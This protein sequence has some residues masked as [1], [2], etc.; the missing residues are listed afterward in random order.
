MKISHD[1]KG[2]GVLEDNKEEYI[3]L[4]NTNFKYMVATEYIS[5]SKVAIEIE[6]KVEELLTYND[7]ETATTVFK[8]QAIQSTI[9]L[10]KNL[11]SLFAVNIED[12][13]NLYF[14][15]NG[16]VKQLERKLDNSRLQEVDYCN[17]IKGLIGN[18][19]TKESVEAITASGGE[20]LTK[21]KLLSNMATITTLDE[22]NTEFNRLI[23]EVTSYE[24]EKLVSV[25]KNYVTKT[26]SVG[27]IKTL[28]ILVLVV[29]TA[30]LL[31]IYIPNRTSQLKA[32]SSYEDKVYEDVL[33]NLSKTNISAMSPV[34]K[35]IEAESTV[36][37]SQLSDNQKDNI[38][39]N[40]SPSVEEGI[41]D[42]W[43][44][45]GQ[46]DLDMAYDQS[47]KNNDAQ[48]KAYVLL[49]LIDRTQNDTDLKQA[50]KDSM[51]STYQGELDSITSSMN[52]KKSGDK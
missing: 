33:T 46:E 16:E 47:I 43:V 30:F 8:L 29:I 37:L 3:N 49:L 5:N 36:R 28:L 12:I 19:L 26:K 41:L 27:R 14:T 52:D 35:Y 51:L 38:L 17:Q 20:L 18:L 9:N 7:L 24:S 34:V 31:V 15:K 22:M 1:F 50:E 23:S 4:L 45:I 6:Y 48:Q 13:E 39:Y 2:L 11:N 42:F 32:V 21:D 44:Y 25:K 10:I 40:L